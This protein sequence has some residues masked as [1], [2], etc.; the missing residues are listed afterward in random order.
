[1]EEF[2]DDDIPFISEKTKKVLKNI[3]NSFLIYN[4][5]NLDKNTNKEQFFEYLNDIIQLDEKVEELATIFEDNEFIYLPKL[6]LYDVLTYYV[7]YPDK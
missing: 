3:T 1:M 6:S 4:M 5:I 2:N 7:L